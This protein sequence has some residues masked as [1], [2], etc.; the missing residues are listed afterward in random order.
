MLTCPPALRLCLPF[1]CSGGTRVALK[2]KLSSPTPP[3]TI[4]P[5]LLLLCLMRGRPWGCR[6]TPMLSCLKTPIAQ[7]T[8]ADASGSWHKRR[9][10]G[11]EA[12]GEGSVCAAREAGWLPGRLREPGPWQLCT[13]SPGQGR[14]RQRAITCWGREGGG[15]ESGILADRHGMP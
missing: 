11:S 3:P 5:L 8:C 10:E 6:D 7:G 12:S 14:A 13:R 1:L 4:C 9:A 2:V 15:G